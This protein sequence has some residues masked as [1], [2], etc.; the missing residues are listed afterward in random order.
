MGYAL[1]KNAIL[2]HTE[3]KVPRVSVRSVCTLCQIFSLKFQHCGHPN[4]GQD[5]SFIEQI[6]EG[7]KFMSPSK[8]KDFGL[9][10]KILEHPPKEGLKD[11]TTEASS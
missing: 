1:L 11:E 9:I 5:L 6:M 8:A 4:T 10:D 7:D 3:A 2:L